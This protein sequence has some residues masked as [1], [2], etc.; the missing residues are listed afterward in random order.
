MGI[1]YKI[2]IYFL[3]IITNRI[4]IRPVLAGGVSANSGLRVRME[5]ECARRGFALYAPPLPLCGDNAAMVGAQAY[6]EFLAGHTAGTDLNACA[7][8]P[9]EG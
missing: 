7:T 1:I 6:Y 5:T 8:M 4:A 9:I 2:S 3:C